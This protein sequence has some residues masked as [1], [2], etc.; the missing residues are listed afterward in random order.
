L[1]T[2]GGPSQSTSRFSRTKRHVA[3]SSTCFFLIDGLNAQ[4]NWSN[5]FSSRNSAALTDVGVG[6]RP[7][8][9][10]VLQDQFEEFP[11]AQAVAGRLLEPDLQ[12]LQQA[13]KAER[14][15]VR[16]SRRSCQN[17]LPLESL[18]DETTV[19]G[20]RTDHRMLVQERHHFLLLDVPVD[21]GADRPQVERAVT[22]RHRAGAFDRGGGIA[23]AKLDRPISTRTASTPARRPP[24]GPARAVRAD[25]PTRA[26]CHAAPRSTPLI[27]SEAMWIGCVL[28]RPA[29]A[30]VDGDRLHPVIEQPHQRAS[31]RPDLTR[32]VLR[33]RRVVGV[34]DSTW[35]SRCTV[36]RASRNDGNG[37][38]GKG[39][40]AARS[41]CST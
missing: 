6:G 23:L 12:A 11:V 17:L 7:H 38:N 25:R 21:Q 4:S 36:R 29:H 16:A 37:S 5:G 41:V 13:R 26:R 20:Q 10:L 32:E 22:R 19:V 35:P 9:Q 24:F 18:V 33:R 2:P 31:Q 27:F 30:H 40:N 34:L 14:F 3:K 39:S 8:R 15:K 28:N 1:P